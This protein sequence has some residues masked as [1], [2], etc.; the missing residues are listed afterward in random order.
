MEELQDAV[1]WFSG[2]G[3]TAEQLRSA[4]S[5]L[6]ARKHK[7]FGYYLRS[8]VSPDDTVHF[9]LRMAETDELCGSMDVDPESGRTWVQ[10]AH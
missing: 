9:S 2:G 6:E 8:R 7:R 10:L 3:L 5:T 1:R 4:V